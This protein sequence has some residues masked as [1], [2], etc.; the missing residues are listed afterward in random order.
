MPEEVFEIAYHYDAAGEHQSAL[1][2][3]LKAGDRARRQYALEIAE[4]QY[5][6]ADRGVTAAPQKIRLKVAEGLG[7]VLLLRGHYDQAAE[8][9]HRAHALSEDALD[10]ARVQGKLGDLAFKRGDVGAAGERIELALRN[11][12][13]RPPSTR[14]G[15][16]IRLLWELL[17]QLMHTLLPRIFLGHRARGDAEAEFQAIRL[18]SRLAH[19]YWF[20][21]GRIPCGWAHLREMNL[22]ER[23]QA[24]PE[25]AQAYSEHAPVMT[26]V[27]Y[28]SRGVRYA[29]KSLEIRRK[30]GDLWGQAQSL[31]FSGI[32]LYAASRFEEAIEHCEQ[33]VE[34]LERTG[35]RWEI[36]TARWHI[37]F[38][39]YRL[40]WL[41]EAIQMA[42]LVYE[43]GIA[44]GDA[45]AR[46][47]SLGVWSK[48]ARGHLPEAIL[49]G[50]LLR[51]SDDAHT[52]AETL[53]AEALRLLL[54]EKKASEAVAV[55]ERAQAGVQKAGLRQEYV[56]PI[57]PWM[58]TALRTMCAE[59]PPYAERERRHLLRKA[60]RVSRRALLLA[61]AYR[62]NLPHAL[63]ERALIFAMQGKV[64]AA[65]ASI[66][67]SIEVASEQGAR[68]ELAQSLVA[69]G[70]IG[71]SLGWHKADKDLQ[72]GKEMCWSLEVEPEDAT[73]R[74]SSVSLIDRFDSLLE[75]GRRLSSALS[76]E[77]VL[78]GVEDSVLRL[79]RAEHCA[80]VEFGPERELV[81]KRPGWNV[82]PLHCA[83][84]RQALGAGRPVV[85]DE[86]LGDE[87]ADS[88]LT[89]AAPSRLCT[90]ILLHGQPVACFV[91]L[92]T[93][94]QHFFGPEELRLAEFVSTVASV[95]LENAEGF[96]HV[97]ALSSER[98]KLFEQ[99]QEAI[100]MRDEFM[101]VAA[102]ELRTPLSALV[103]HLAG[104]NQ[105][106]QPRRAALGATRGHGRVPRAAEHREKLDKALRQTRRL[107]ALVD[108]LLDVSR[109]TVGHLTLRREHFDFSE[110]VAEV[111]ER[112]SEDA[113]RAGCPL[114]L[115]P[116]ASSPGSWD[117]LRMEQVITNLLSNA[118]KYGSGHP[119]HISTVNQNDRVV[120][121]VRDHGIG[122][123]ESDLQRIF[124]R[125]ER[126]VSIRHYGG[127]GLGLFIARQIVEA[128]GGSISVRSQKGLGTTFTVEV[129][130]SS[131]M[132]LELS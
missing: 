35:D 32:V 44:I 36:N 43:D 119:I 108:N 10:S 14:L 94:I 9:L 83:L 115:S 56:A 79:L 100:C 4:Q 49:D 70:H 121:T 38:S 118:I 95:A 21:R 65:Q 7:D 130:R 75:S 40:G 113:S 71:V 50:E 57:L 61:R 3:A 125:F 132:S 53:Q 1:P 91:A 64:N 55:L 104:L 124:E 103:L 76:R 59:A 131:Q 8:W 25:L 58:A 81:Q 127:L 15:F 117:R 20:Q 109:I 86:M 110:M 63:R 62:N 16:F 18:Y 60:S 24:S 88:A 128:H 101:S 78:D 27:P 92:H 96:S 84:V 34:L 82:L 93:K 42:R 54:V 5:R 87:S 72:R 28:Y 45:Q 68:H 73:P 17:V 26:M 120:I 2:Y 77:A 22:A 99:A 85:G 30:L 102:H 11:L 33:A 41:D 12:G 106:L 107:S 105:Q 46:G 90:P 19:V 129:P 6:I 13:R 112:F 116:E 66:D 67:E 126:A 39:L 48:A 89:I 23:Y 74:S 123:G 97:E 47:I 69:R 114:E 111:A 98:A 122:I 31:H 52:V 80:I 51:P 37:A 29:K